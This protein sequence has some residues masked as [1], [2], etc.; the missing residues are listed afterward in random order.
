MCRY[1]Q[2]KSCIQKKKKSGKYYTTKKT[3]KSLMNDP[4]EM[5][6]CELADK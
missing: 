4:K 3:D 5:R 1:Q 2:K 6:I